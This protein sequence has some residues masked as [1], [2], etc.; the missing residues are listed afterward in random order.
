MKECNHLQVVITRNFRISTLHSAV[1][2]TYSTE[3]RA[4]LHYVRTASLAVIIS[5]GHTVAPVFNR[6]GQ[7]MW[8]LWRT[9]DVIHVIYFSIYH[10][11]NAPQLSSNN[12]AAISK[13]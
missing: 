2:S 11:T 8:D 9:K 5:R 4:V 6:M 10:S 12:P 7:S 3:R 13:F 1:L